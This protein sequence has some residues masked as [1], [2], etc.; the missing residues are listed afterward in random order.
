MF[1]DSKLPGSIPLD[2]P[3]YLELEKKLSKTFE[4]NTSIDGVFKGYNI[5]FVTNEYGEHV[6]LFVGK[7]RPSVP[8]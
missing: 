7:V 6:T 3:L 2:M 5:T 4:P 8:F 1:S